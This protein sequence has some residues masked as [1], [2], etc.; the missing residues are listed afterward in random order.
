MAPWEQQLGPRNSC[1]TPGTPESIPGTPAAPWED[2][3]APLGTLQHPWNSCSTPR[4]QGPC[5][6]G[7]TV[8]APSNLKGSVP[9]PTE[10]L[11]PKRPV[12]APRVCV[13]TLCCHPAPMETQWDTGPSGTLCQHPQGHSACRDPI[14]APCVLGDPVPACL[15]TLHPWGPRASTLGDTMPTEI[16]ASIPGDTTAMGTLCQHPGGLGTSRDPCG[17]PMP[18]P[19]PGGARGRSPRGSHRPA[20]HH[21]R[22]PRGCPGRS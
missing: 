21:G 12:P 22:S 10:D 5:T 13:G 7:D 20:P 4:P 1:S 16:S 14:P 17:S 8:P 3:I 18:C 6:P 15:G 11:G 19:V 2:W 9:A